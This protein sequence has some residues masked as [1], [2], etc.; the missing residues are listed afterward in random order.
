MTSYLIERPTGWYFKR[1]VPRKLVSIIGRSL[2]RETLKAGTK[3][4]AEIAVRPLIASTDEEIRK[5]REE[6]H[7][8]RQAIT[9]LTPDERAVLQEAGGFSG[10]RRAID[11]ERKSV[12]FAVAAVETFA[13][14]AEEPRGELAD[15]GINLDNLQDELDDAERHLTR[16]RVRIARNESILARKGLKPNEAIQPDD[17]PLDQSAKADI[18]LSA[19]VE[20]W[21]KQI[22][23]PNSTRTS[24]TIRSGCSLRSGTG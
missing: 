17:L 9:M 21:V 2:W 16:L 3:A 22:I 15:E 7:R 12:P 14:L 5:A 19:L 20:H 23:R 10:L 24:I 18:D 1:A 11:A 8:Q 13:S 4:R 6:L